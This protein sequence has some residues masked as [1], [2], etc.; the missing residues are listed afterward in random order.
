MQRTLIVALAG[1]LIAGCSTAEHTSNDD[2]L[3]VRARLTGDAYA[4]CE[5]FLESWRRRIQLE[6]RAN[7]LVPAMLVGRAAHRAEGTSVETVL[8]TYDAFVARTP[9]D[10]SDGVPEALPEAGRRGFMEAQDEARMACIA[11][12]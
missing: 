5:L 4:A 7:D 9:S 8:R 3:Q 10:D 11:P 6:E 12:S 1:L 2:G